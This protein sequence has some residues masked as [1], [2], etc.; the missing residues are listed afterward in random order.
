[1]LRFGLKKCNAKNMIAINLLDWRSKRI[2]ILN[3]RFIAILTAAS[4]L[5]ALIT[6]SGSLIIDSMINTVKSDIA[7]LDSE[8]Q[9]VE[10]KIQQIKDLQESKQLLL[11]RRKVIETL[12]QS[13]PLVVNIFDNI[14]RAIPSD[15][16]LNEMTRKTDILTISGVSSSNSGITVLMDNLQK[17]SWVKDAKLG[18][19]RTAEVKES[20][21]NAATNTLP[22]IEFHIQIAI[23]AQGSGEQ[24]AAT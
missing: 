10:G 4:F 1:M 14:A 8:L 21:K 6:L 13:R 17:L 20:D 9:S 12:Q 19:I 22:Q 2:K 18:E 24:N 15:I 11:S 16:T 5:T 23:A 3:H 7:Y